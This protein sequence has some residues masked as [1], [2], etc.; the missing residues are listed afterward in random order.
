MKVTAKFV[1][2]D[3][4]EILATFDA[5]AGTVTSSDGRAGTYSRTSNVITIDGADQKLTLTMGGAPEQLA[6]GYSTTFTS[7]TGASGTVTI[8]SVG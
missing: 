1:G 5:V 3:G 7:S 4:R 8:L 2:Q 6:P